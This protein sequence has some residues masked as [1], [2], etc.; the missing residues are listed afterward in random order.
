[1]DNDLLHSHGLRHLSGVLS[2]Y[3]LPAVGFSLSTSPTPVSSGV[4]RFG[5]EP[6]FPVDGEWPSNRGRP[7]DFL[8]QVNLSEVSPF[9]GSAL[10]PSS[11]LLSF[12]Y[13]L[14]EQPWGFDPNDL[15]GFRVVFS[16]PT[17]RLAPREV[18]NAE[19]R[20]PEMGI[21]FCQTSTL[22]HVGSRAMERFE[23]EA[24][25]SEQQWERYLDFVEEYEAQ[26]YP[27]GSGR[28]RLLGH[29]A[30]VQGDMQL[31]AQL[32]TN[33]LYCGDQ[34]GYEDP[35]AR[36]LEDGA[37]EWMLLLQ[38]DSDDGADFMWGDGGML[39]FWIRS[40]DLRQHRFDKVWMTLQC[41]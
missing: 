5:G 41:G 18:P 30:N 24:N 7:L 32:V 33:G 16:P 13:D 36:G 31:E 40:G 2:R 10:L 14:Q 37:D 19:Y 21:S 39:Y 9:D 29:S 8:L 38:L 12:F 23:S 17:T 35:R 11:G 25:L 3:E 20:W 27:Q 26:F 6:D 28:H 22:P 4:S 34:T 1:M 15:G